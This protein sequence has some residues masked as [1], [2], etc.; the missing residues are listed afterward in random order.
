MRFDNLLTRLAGLERGEGYV[1]LE[2]GTR[3]APKHSGISLWFAQMKLG[4]DLDREPELADF[5]E[6]E[7]KQW[8]CY[9]KWADPDPGKHGAISVL[10]V[11]EAKKL[12][13]G[14]G[15]CGE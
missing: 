13:C 4:Q 2:D 6:E 10:L 8:Q 7:Q 9:A 15:A 14:V 5:T 12:C 11:T 1:I 3:F